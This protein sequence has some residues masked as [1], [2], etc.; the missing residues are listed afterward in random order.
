M[1][2]ERSLTALALQ[3]IALYNKDWMSAFATNAFKFYEKVRYM[4]AFARE[5]FILRRNQ[6]L[7]CH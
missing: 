6:F 7:K 2:N 3:K 5:M 1:R 4:F